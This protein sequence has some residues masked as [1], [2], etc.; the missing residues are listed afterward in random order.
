MDAGVDARA[1]SPMA[2]KFVGTIGA[3]TVTGAL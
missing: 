1:G 3:M 2:V